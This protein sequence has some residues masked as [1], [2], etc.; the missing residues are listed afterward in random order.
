MP[1][2]IPYILCSTLLFAPAS[3]FLPNLTVEAK[4]EEH[5]NIS[6]NEGF[7]HTLSCL[8]TYTHTNVEKGHRLDF[9]PNHTCG[10]NLY[11]KSDR[12]QDVKH[13]LSI[14]VVTPITIRVEQFAIHNT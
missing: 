7:T 3:R 9:L 6:A 8:L 1:L 4:H 14:F 2:T 12:L 10:R 13:F 11:C 5:C